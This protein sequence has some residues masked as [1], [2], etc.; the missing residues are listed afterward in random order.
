M[1]TNLQPTS[2]PAPA[3][4]KVA[5][6]PDVTAKYY[7]YNPNSYQVQAFIKGIFRDRYLA[8]ITDLKNSQTHKWLKEF[9]EEADWNAILGNADRHIEFGRFWV[10]P[11]EDLY[12]AG[13]SLAP[14]SG[15]HINIISETDRTTEK[16]VVRVG[17]N[18][19]DYVNYF[20]DYINFSQFMDGLKGNM[21]NSVK[22]TLAMKVTA[23][24]T[25]DPS[26]VIFDNREI[27]RVFNKT[28]DNRPATK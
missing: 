20:F 19:E 10:E 12:R 14:V 18:R 13:V 23:I 26:S 4:P 27:S 11:Y 5:Y 6:N 17:Y 7:G 25:A 9:L 21:I 16:V 15:H 1:S 24:L 28:W 3:I 2:F 22:D 8:S